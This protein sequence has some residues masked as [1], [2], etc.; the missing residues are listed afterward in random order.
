VAAEWALGIISRFESV[1][2]HFPRRNPRKR[3]LAVNSQRSGDRCG[4]TLSTDR[5]QQ[6]QNVVKLS[7]G[8]EQEIR[9][10]DQWI[11]YR[12]LQAGVRLSRSAKI[13]K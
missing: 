8:G 10:V 11:E 9:N 7:E 5:R 2:T 1:H 6:Q 3:V 13:N 12:S 4:P